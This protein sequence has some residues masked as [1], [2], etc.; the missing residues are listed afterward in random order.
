M[1]LCVVLCV[2]MLSP[3]FGTAQSH[4]VQQLLLNVEKLAQ[5]KKILNNLYTGYEILSKGYTAIKNISEGNFSIH[6]VFLD[7]LLEVSP[8]VRKYK[9]V[10][11][12]IVAQKRIVKEYRTAFQNF[13]K[14]G[15]FSE[16]ELASM[17]RTYARLMM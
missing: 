2:S 6:Q 11:D 7:K 13:K 9:R 5:L 15:S 8:T 3:F 16:T 17:G 14:S 1:L 4:E 10:A 12:I